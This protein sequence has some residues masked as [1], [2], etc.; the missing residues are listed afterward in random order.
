MSCLER[1]AQPAAFGRNLRGRA[2][3]TCHF[4]Y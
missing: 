3:C 4:K 1:V 2:H